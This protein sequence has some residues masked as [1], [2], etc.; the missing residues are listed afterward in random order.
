MG[1]DA[2]VIGGDP[3][4]STLGDD[5]AEGAIVLLEEADSQQLGLPQPVLL[6]LGP[7]GRGYL[8][9]VTAVQRQRQRRLD[10]QQTEQDQ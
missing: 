10:D 7:A 9:V 1:E 2:E 4:E 3:L 8:G 6:G 5:H